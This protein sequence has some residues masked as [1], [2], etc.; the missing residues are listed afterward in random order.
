MKTW[1]EIKKI[2][3]EQSYWMKPYIILNI[4]LRKATKIEFGKD[5]LNF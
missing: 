2:N 3:F 1:P 4:M 5:F